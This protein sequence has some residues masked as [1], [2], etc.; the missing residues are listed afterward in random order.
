M[1]DRSAK[2]LWASRYQGGA[3]LRCCYFGVGG[4]F[5]IFNQNN[6]LAQTRASQTCA[7]D[8]LSCS[9]SPPCLSVNCHFDVFIQNHFFHVQIFALALSAPNTQF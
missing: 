1:Q 8:Y 7:H 3:C 6:Y 2:M 4:G 5:D 9:C